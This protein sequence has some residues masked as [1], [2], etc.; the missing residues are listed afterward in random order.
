MS[1]I[2]LASYPKS[3]NTWVRAFLTNYQR[4]SDQPADINT[5]NGGPIA[6]DRHLFDE[7]IGMSSSD[8]TTDEIERYRPLFYNL[9][10]ADCASTRFIKVHDAYSYNRDGQ[11]LFPISATSGVIYVVRNPLDVVVSYAHHEYKS[12]DDI[13]SRMNLSR[14]TILNSPDV[15]YTQLPQ[16]LLS[17][18]GH[19]RS[20]LE[21]TDL[22]VHI[23]QYEEL[24][25]RPLATFTEI[26]R[27]CGLPQDVPRIKKAIDFSCFD[28]LYDQEVSR[29][30]AEKQPT[31]QSFFRQGKA[32]DWQTHLTRGQVQQLA[33]THHRIM[34]R[35]GYLAGVGLFLRRL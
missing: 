20:W 6:T 29:G 31:S 22:N 9:L 28:R 2:W 7:Y 17:W 1:I 8:M 12:L 14:F 21:Q 23:V 13:I 34:D 35:F 30:F 5:L 32:G 24:L 19:V 11:A 4:N 10:A 18:S 25:Q 15:L 27:F 26:V 3:G 16:T 33:E